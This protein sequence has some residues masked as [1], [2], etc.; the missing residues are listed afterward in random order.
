MFI[1]EWY[2]K[3]FYR[4][5]A[6]EYRDKHSFGQLF[7]THAYYPHENLEIWR[8]VANAGD[9][10]KTLAK[11]FQ[12]QAAGGDEFNRR[13]P[14]HAPKLETNEEFVVVRAKKRP[15]I[16][17]Q[18]ASSL[19]ISDN[20]GFRGRWQRKRCLV[21]QIFGL[22]DSV[23]GRAEF[24]SA[25][26]DRVRRMEFPE[27]MFLPKSP[28]YLDMDSLLRLD[29]MQS[30][31]RPHLEPKGL[32]LNPELCEILRHQFQFLI[33]GSVPSPYTIL[34]ELLLTD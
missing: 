10:T 15:V 25:L 20:K 18:P 13:I 32:A 24:D 2:G 29:E 30:V 27:L 17:M 8:P 9:A 31:F 22:S 12:L 26:V 21:A 4:Q 11:E 7:W 19:D 33:T 16:L 5:L 1:D 3:E 6:G 14:L 34:R 23:T 28:G